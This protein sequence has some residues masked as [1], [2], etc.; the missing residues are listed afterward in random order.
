MEDKTITFSWKYKGR[1]LDIL[2]IRLKAFLFYLFLGI[3]LFVLM[4]VIL[5]TNYY[6]VI[7][8]FGTK[9]V[10]WVLYY[11]IPFLLLFLPLILFFLGVNKGFEKKATFVFHKTKEGEY[12]VHV[13]TTRSKKDYVLD[14]RVNLID[15][16]KRLYKVTTVQKAETFYLPKKNLRKEDQNYLEAIEKEIRDHRIKETIDTK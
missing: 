3:S 10:F 9:K 8:I 2:M 13:C 7:D 1:F 16:Q 12:T 15:I 11:T 4:A 6:K 5:F 14:D